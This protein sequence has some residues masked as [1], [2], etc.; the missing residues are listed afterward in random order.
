MRPSL[1][2]TSPRLLL[3]LLAFLGF[4]SA[5]AAAL[6]A[7][8]PTHAQTPAALMYDAQIGPIAFGAGDLKTT[9]AANG[10]GVTVLP[11]GDPATAKQS[12]R[13][14][15]STETARFRAGQHRA[16]VGKRLL[17]RDAR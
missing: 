15:V 14:I 3:P 2:K 9:L 5:V 10:Y 12:V 8:A 11:P 1:H 7:F 13:I 17:D 6:L 4:G 16:H